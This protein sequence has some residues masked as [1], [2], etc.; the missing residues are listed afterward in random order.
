MSLFGQPGWMWGA[1]VSEAVALLLVVRLWRSG[2][3]LAL[4]LALSVLALIPVAGPLL[5]LWL[6]NFPDPLPPA[7]QDRSPKTTD[8]LD[9]WRHVLDEKHTARR[10]LAWRRLVHPRRDD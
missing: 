3:F 4:K 1:A 5:V 7:L 8:V 9:R 6:S 2:D 10:F